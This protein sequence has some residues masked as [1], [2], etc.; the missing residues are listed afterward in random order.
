[1]EIGGAERTNAYPEE[2]GS[3]LADAQGHDLEELGV[4]QAELDAN[5]THTYLKERGA[6]RAWQTLPI[7][8]LLE[9]VIVPKGVASNIQRAGAQYQNDVQEPANDAGSD[10]CE[11]KRLLA[12]PF[13]MDL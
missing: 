3:G 12:K 5:R 8:A 13:V 7:E 10:D 2:E 1:M 9:F 6:G 4:S 11:V